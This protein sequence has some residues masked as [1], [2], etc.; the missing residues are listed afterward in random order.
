VSDLTGSAASETST[1]ADTR[2]AAAA[3]AL[4]DAVLEWLRTNNQVP[5]NREVVAV[6]FA[7]PFVARWLTS[8]GRVARRSGTIVPP[9]G[10]D[11]RSLGD[12]MLRHA[13]K[14]R[15]PLDQIDRLD[16]DYSRTPVA[17]HR[18]LPGCVADHSAEPL[19][20]RRCW[21]RIGDC[22]TDNDSPA[23]VELWGHQI[24][25]PAGT[26]SRIRVQLVNHGTG[27]RM[28]AD[29]HRTGPTT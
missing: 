10:P 19:D 29:M 2:R 27:K 18:Y 5:E 14:L 15:R 8:G 20:R 22:Y 11:L 12:M 6:D 24:T 4:A 13:Q 28:A 23:S 26:Q 1:P 9:D 7:V 16:V 3:Q 21:V 25:T 17:R